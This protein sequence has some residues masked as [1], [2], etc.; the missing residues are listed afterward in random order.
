MGGEC[1]KDWLPSCN[2]QLTFTLWCNSHLITLYTNHGCYLAATCQLHVVTNRKV[3]DRSVQLCSVGVMEQPHPADE[4]TKN[5]KGYGVPTS[6]LMP[7]CKAASGGL[8]RPAQKAARSTR[9]VYRARISHSGLSIGQGLV[10]SPQPGTELPNPSRETKFSGA[11][12]DRK[13]FIFPVQLTTGRIGNLTRL[14][15]TL[16]ICVNIQRIAKRS[17]VCEEHGWYVLE[18]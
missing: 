3:P 5:R 16:T 18:K 10:G 6:D 12:A 14:I 4:Q 1:Y 17:H 13:L 15:H 11:D 8:Q 7:P 2:R 9:N